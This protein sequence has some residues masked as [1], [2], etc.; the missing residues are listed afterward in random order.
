[1]LS[2]YVDEH[3]VGESEIVT[4]P[5]VF[6]LCGDGLCVGRDSGSPVGDD[7]APP[8]TF[9]GGVIDRVVVDVSGDA[10]RGSREGGSR[11]AGARLGPF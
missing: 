6:S 10:L 4:Q 8:F 9:A 2:L 11:L 3:K 1:M 5:G 7:Y